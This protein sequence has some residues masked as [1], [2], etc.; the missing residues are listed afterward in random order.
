MAD[1]AKNGLKD[2]FEQF[3]AKA[4]DSAVLWEF[5]VQQSTPIKLILWSNFPQYHERLREEERKQQ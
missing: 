1:T 3:A 4:D 5:Y 2:L